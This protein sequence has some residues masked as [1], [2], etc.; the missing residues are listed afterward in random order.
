M[1]QDLHFMHSR[2][3]LHLPGGFSFLRITLFAW[4]IA[5]FY[6][7]FSRNSQHMIFNRIYFFKSLAIGIMKNL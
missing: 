6:K 7:F 1:D 2:P 4:F 3:D 5:I